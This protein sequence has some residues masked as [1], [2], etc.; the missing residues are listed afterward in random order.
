MWLEDT[1]GGVYDVVTHHMGMVAKAHRKVLLLEPLEL[2]EGCSREELHAKG[3]HYVPA[4][5]PTQQ[6]LLRLFVRDWQADALEDMRSMEALLPTAEPGVWTRLPMAAGGS[7]GSGSSDPGMALL[8]LLMRQVALSG[9]S[10]GRQA[11]AKAKPGSR[12]RG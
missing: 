1:E 6:D 3:L 4:S 5:G 9:G 2:I 10:A 7:G 12:R 11:K 8:Q